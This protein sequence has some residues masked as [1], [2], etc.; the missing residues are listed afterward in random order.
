MKLPVH[1]AIVCFEISWSINKRS[2]LE[3][4]P[5]F[6]VSSNGMKELGFGHEILVCMSTGLSI[7]PWPLLISAVYNQSTTL[8]KLSYIIYR[9]LLCQHNSTFYILHIYSSLT[10]PPL[11][12]KTKTV[13]CNF[14][15]FAKLFSWNFVNS[16]MHECVTEFSERLWTSVHAS[17]HTTQ[18]LVLIHSLISE[19]SPEVLRTEDNCACLCVL[20]VPLENSAQ[21]S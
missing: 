3:T 5:L 21:V 16:I 6:T 4:G 2:H 19:K 14:Y 7:T 9:E 1:L 18:N 20:Y 8:Q 12:K 11:G 15:K 10:R 13:F 17:L